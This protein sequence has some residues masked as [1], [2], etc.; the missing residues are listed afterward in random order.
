MKLKLVALIAALAVPVLGWA[1][2]T[3]GSHCS[4]PCGDHCPIPCKDCP[5]GKR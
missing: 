4:L 1:A 2:S 3:L 5:L